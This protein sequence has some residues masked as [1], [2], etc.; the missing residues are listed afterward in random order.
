MNSCIAVE[1][2]TRKSLCLNRNALRDVR[3]NA[4]FANR[5]NSVKSSDHPLRGGHLDQERISALQS[6]ELRC[7]CKDCDCTDEQS[8]Q[9]QYQLSYRLD[10]EVSP[11]DAYG[12]DCARA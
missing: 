2:C 6:A 11:Q 1:L 7:Q 3:F 12:E 9:V 5:A 10:S 4:R 8:R